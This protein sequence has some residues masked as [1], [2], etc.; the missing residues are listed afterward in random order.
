M[1]LSVS[2]YP[3]LRQQSKVINSDTLTSDQAEQ[4]R[5]YLGTREGRINNLELGKRD[6]DIFKVASSQRGK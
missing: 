4:W 5:L 2:D 3:Q 6:G 1:T